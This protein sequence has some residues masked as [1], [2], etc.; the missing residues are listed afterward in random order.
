MY[1]DLL[2]QIT[3]YLKPKERYYLLFEIFKSKSCCHLYLIYESYNEIKMEYELNKLSRNLSMGESIK[4]FIYHFQI[5]EGLMIGFKTNHYFGL[6]FLYLSI[7][8]KQLINIKWEYNLNYYRDF[9][10]L[11]LQFANIKKEIEDKHSSSVYLIKRDIF[12]I[13]FGVEFD[14]SSDNDDYD[15]YYDDKDDYPISLH[16]QRDLFRLNNESIK[17]IKKSL[18]VLLKIDEFGDFSNIELDEE[19]KK[20]LKIHE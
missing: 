9:D 2:R 12:E 17:S 5:D 16:F 8:K 6:P 13:C 18:E 4:P 14:G 20:Y 15:N 10:K 11:K 3:K 19:K 1:A 7:K